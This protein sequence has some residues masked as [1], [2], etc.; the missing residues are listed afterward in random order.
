MS[1]RLFLFALPSVYLS[2]QPGFELET[3]WVLSVATVA[4]QMV[5]SLLLAQREL[6]KKLSGLMPLTE[7]QGA[8]SIGGK[9]GKVSGHK[10]LVQE[11]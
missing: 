7:P 3:L 4:I 8:E 9:S 1:S 10:I 5:I 11:S 6:N 2:Q